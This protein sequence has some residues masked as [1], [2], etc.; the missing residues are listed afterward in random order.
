MQSFSFNSETP[1]C[2]VS[3]DENSFGQIVGNNYFFNETMNVEF[4]KIASI[5]DFMIPE[6]RE[7]HRIRMKKF[8]QEDCF[9]LEHKNGFMLNTKGKLVFT[10]ILVQIMPSILEGLRYVFFL[11]K[12]MPKR[13]I[14]GLKNN[15]TIAYS[16]QSF[17]DAF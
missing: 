14:L 13:K 16:S 17:D 15:L 3:V 9:S 1:M 4:G 7:A 2:F 5:E 12:L 6:M 11:K 10:K 8:I